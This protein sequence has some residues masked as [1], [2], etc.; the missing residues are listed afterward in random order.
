MRD[1][2]IGAGFE[3]RDDSKDVCFYV[4][5]RMIVVCFHL[6]SLLVHYFLLYNSRTKIV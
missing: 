4:H 3:K 6:N 5:F 1:G 2:V